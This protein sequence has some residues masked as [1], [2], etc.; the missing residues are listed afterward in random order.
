MSFSRRRLLF[1]AASLPLLAS[2]AT[3]GQPRKFTLSPV[4]GPAGGPGWSLSIAAPRALKSLDSER[5]AHRPDALELQ[6][7]TGADWVDRAP[8]MLQMLM[9]RSFQNRSNL[10]VTALD[11]PG[12]PGDF[13]LTSLL[14]DFQSEGNRA[15]ITLV[16]SLARSNRRQDTRTQVFEA[17]AAAGSDH[18]DAMVAAFDDAFAEIMKKMIP[19]SLAAGEEMRRNS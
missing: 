16:A 15:H 4:S 1:A 6:Y 10:Q 18:M 14:Q 9:I 8:Q 11:M 2:C 7:Y 12:P 3:S 19:W 17:S 5:I 13:L